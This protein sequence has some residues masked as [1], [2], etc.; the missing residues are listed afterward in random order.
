MFSFVMGTK[1]MLR[2]THVGDGLLGLLLYTSGL[3]KSLLDLRVKLHYI[4][5]QL[6][7]GVEE[8]GVLIRV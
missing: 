2:A 6:L 8:T 5:L 4:R 1:T 7:L 3:L